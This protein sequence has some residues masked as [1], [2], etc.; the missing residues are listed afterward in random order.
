MLASAY[1]R[2]GASMI[3]WSAYLVLGRSRFG[4]LSSTFANR[5]TQPRCSRVSDHAFPTLAQKP[6]ALSP[7]TRGPQAAAILVPQHRGPALRA[8]AIAVFFGYELFR[9]VRADANH[10]Q[11]AEPILLEV[12]QE[13][14]AIHQDVHVIC[15]GQAP[16]SGCQSGERAHPA[17]A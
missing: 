15:G 1:A 17:A 11:R 16:Q 6:S 9:A 2:V 7:T 4:S 14:H 13:V 10:H 5:C 3:V 8:F 12:H